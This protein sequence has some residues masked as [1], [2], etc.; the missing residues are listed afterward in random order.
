[1]RYFP[2][3]GIVTLTDEAASDAGLDFGPWEWRALVWEWLD[4]GMVIFAWRD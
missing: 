2:F 4:G 3:L 1:M